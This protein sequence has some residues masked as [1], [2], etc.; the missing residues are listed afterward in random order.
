MTQ[1]NTLPKV[2][3]FCMEYGLDDSFK[4]YAGGL[5]ILAGDYLKGAKDHD[6][7][8]IGIGIKWKQGYTEQRINDAGRPVD[9]YPIYD[10]D[11]LEDTG[12][13]VKVNIRNRAV[14]AKVWKCTAFGNVDLYLLDTDLPGNNDSWITGQLYGWFG[15]E[16]VAQEM[17]LG[18]G[19]VRALRALGIATD[20]Y[21]FNEGH[22]LFAGFELLREHMEQGLSFEEAWTATKAQVVFTTHTPILQGNE[23]HP[24]ELLQYMGANMGLNIDQLVRIGGAPFNMTVGALRLS[25][26]SNAVA[27]LHSD[28]AN[29]MW[30]HVDNRS[31][32]VGITNAIHC[33]TWVDSKMLAAAASG[34]DLWEPHQENKRKLIRFIK[35]RTGKNFDEQKLLIGFSRRA[36]PYKRS[37]LIFSKP[38][39][40][41]PLLESGKVQLVFS[42]KAHPLDDTGKDIAAELV[43]YARKYDSVA[44][45]E[46][47]SME[48]GAALTRGAD[49]W[50]N[51]PRRPLEASGTSGMK[52]AMNGV[53]NCSILDGWWPEACEHGV[54]GWQF[55]DGQEFDTEA[56]LDAHDR[57]ALYQVLT[58]EVIP[59]YYDDKNK[60]AAMMRAS[61]Q[62]TREFFAV[63]RMLQEYYSL[64]YQ[65]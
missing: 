46:N 8:I 11:F 10:Y 19:G 44:F 32:I 35:E 27:Q 2:A 53:L 20:V 43:A 52:A 51:N 13:E 28:T 55:G 1:K 15:E 4:A 24:I 22:A 49:V 17:I 60:W 41:Q 31:E 50:L 40:I 63:K 62:S 61:I 59:T 42:G 14:R 23:S 58:R 38:E 21:H 7:P 33:P 5:G 6:Y 64:L 12:V 47:Y 9:T 45:L 30:A 39:I 34:A 29:K 57:E 16:R 26:A 56:E 25:R 54:N 3:Y 37:N 18:I 36:V 65:H 48:I